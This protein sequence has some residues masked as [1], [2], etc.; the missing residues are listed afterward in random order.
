MVSTRAPISSFWLAN[1][2]ERIALLDDAGGLYVASRSESR[3][4]Q[5]LPVHQ[6]G[7]AKPSTMWPSTP[8]AIGWLRL[9]S[10]K[11]CGCGI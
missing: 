3:E 4:P 8:W 7:L 2:G 10:G 11:D 5:P 1:R 6:R 9:S